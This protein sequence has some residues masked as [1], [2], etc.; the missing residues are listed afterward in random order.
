MRLTL[1]IFTTF[2]VGL[3][4]ILRFY[5]SYLIVEKYLVTAVSDVSLRYRLLCL[6][7]V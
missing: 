1:V 6:Q 7:V 5:E 3:D 2:K 4:H